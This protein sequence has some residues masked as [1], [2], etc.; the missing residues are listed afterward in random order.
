MAES[1]LEV[2][3][4]IRELL[5]LVAEPQ[6]A[7]R[8]KKRRDEL[9]RIAGKGEKNIKAV[10][11]MQGVKSQKEISSE[12]KIDASQLSRLVKSLHSAG[13]LDP[14]SDVPKLVFPVNEQLFLEK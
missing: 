3:K 13:L 14:N 9:R 1:E 10:L 6:L 12:A 11:A 7:E 8:D 2:L 4:D 5:T